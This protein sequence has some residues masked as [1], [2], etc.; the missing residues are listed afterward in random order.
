MATGRRSQ[1]NIKR[2]RHPLDEEL[3]AAIVSAL[4]QYAE[5]SPLSRLAKVLGISPNTLTRY[6]REPT[7]NLGG[8]ILFRMCEVGLNIRCRGKTLRLDESDQPV[9]QTE[10]LRFEF[11]GIVDLQFPSRMMAVRVERVR[12]KEPSEDEAA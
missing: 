12:R 2:P 5:G 1:K 11:V 8:D 10:Q 7:A 3:R 6:L 9:R 4:N